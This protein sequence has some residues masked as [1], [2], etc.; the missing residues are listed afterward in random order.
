MASLTRR[1]LLLASVLLVAC[2]PTQSGTVVD[3]DGAVI[4]RELLPDRQNPGKRVEVFWT[5]PAGSGPWPVAMY[6]HGH[7]EQIR[8]GGEMYVASG[9]LGAMARRGYVAASVS[10]PGYGSSD[11]PA[12]FCGPRTQDAVLQAMAFLRDKPFVNPNRIALYGYSRGAIVAAMVASRDPQL[13]AVVLG[14]GAYDFFTWYPTPLRGINANIV[15]EAG[16]SPEAF[17]ARSA[18]YHIDTIKAPILLLHGRQDE[19]VSVRQ[20]EA[21]HEKLRAAGRSVRMKVFPD[22][23]HGIPFGEQVSEIDPFLAEV[24]R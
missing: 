4:Q 2:A 7:Q 1:V 8:N 16:T 11:G 12:D 18:I 6:I 5:T 20:A 23:R 10:Q 15:N 24:L 14:A 19:R 3:R 17:R 22:A 13:A 9:R 21:F